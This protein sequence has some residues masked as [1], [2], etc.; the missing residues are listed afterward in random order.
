MHQAVGTEKAGE[1]QK[2]RALRATKAAEDREETFYDPTHRKDIQE[3]TQT[4][5]GSWEE[6]L[7][8]SSG[9]SGEGARMFGSHL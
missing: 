8:K 9:S 4:R 3:R 1:N 6:H 2:A 7:K 5:L